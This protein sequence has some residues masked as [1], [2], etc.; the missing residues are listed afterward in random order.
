MIV[1]GPTSFEP[2]LA[3]ASVADALG[4]IVTVV[5]VGAALLD[6]AALVVVSVPVL[7]NVTVRSFEAGVVRL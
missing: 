5:V 2:V 6:G 7:V 3:R 4:V 1:V